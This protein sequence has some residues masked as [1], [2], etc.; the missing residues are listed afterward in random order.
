MLCAEH[1]TLAQPATRKFN[2]PRMFLC[3]LETC[4]WYDWRSGIT[5]LYGSSQLFEGQPFWQC[6][7]HFQFGR[8]G[9]KELSCQ[10]LQVQ[11][12][13]G[14]NTLGNASMCVGFQ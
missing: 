7:Q 3:T 6:L 10:T 11:L 4:L 8:A 2:Y 9:W 13:S 12:A 14:F 5:P 1:S